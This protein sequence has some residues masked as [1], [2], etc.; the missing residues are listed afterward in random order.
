MLKI[1]ILQIVQIVIANKSWFNSW[2]Y[3]KYFTFS[4]LFSKPFLKII[5]FLFQ[6]IK[7]WRWFH[8][9]FHIYIFFFSVL[10]ISLVCPSTTENHNS[11]FW[12]NYKH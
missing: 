6:Y 12:L 2:I 10:H 9:H 3:L 11:V 4:L 8:T 5:L 7:P 1:K